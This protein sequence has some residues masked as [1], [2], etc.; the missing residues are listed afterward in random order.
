RRA[1]A[2]FSSKRRE[3]H[4]TE[5]RKAVFIKSAGFARAF[6]TKAKH[7]KNQNFCGASAR[8]PFQAQPDKGVP[9]LERAPPV[10]NEVFSPKYRLLRACFRDCL[11]P[12]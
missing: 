7:C 3:A 11:P 6:D 9:R 10:S 2:I 1:A 12:S 5:N 8:S 4:K